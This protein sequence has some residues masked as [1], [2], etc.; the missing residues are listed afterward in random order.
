MAF[1]KLNIPKEGI[2]P[3][4]VP[5]LDALQTAQMNAFMA[6]QAAEKEADK[7]ILELQ[8]GEIAAATKIMQELYQKYYYRKASF[9]NLIS[10]KG[11]A[12]EKFAAIN[13]QVV[14]DWV[15]PSIS[16]EQTPPQIT[17]VNRLKEFDAEQNRYEVGKGLADDFYE[18][19]RARM[20]NKSKLIIPGQ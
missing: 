7:E 20:K 19:K 5:K 2:A 9:D 17:I 15:M 11:E 10:L 18:A 14:V 8:E 4:D 3:E 16:V 1:D 13:L 6:E 12:E